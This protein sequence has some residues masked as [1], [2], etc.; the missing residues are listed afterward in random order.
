MNP[1]CNGCGA[2]A[3][4]CKCHPAYS[5]NGTAETQVTGRYPGAFAQQYAGEAWAIVVPCGA[6]GERIGEGASEDG[7]WEAAADSI[8]EDDEDE[9]D[10]R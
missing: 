10:L 2:D 6:F 9:R 1:K 8:Q 3:D 5:G 7:A 4:V